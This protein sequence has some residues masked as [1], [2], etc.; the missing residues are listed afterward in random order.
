MPRSLRAKY[1]VLTEAQHQ[2]YMAKRRAAARTP[3]T[4][5]FRIPGYAR[6]LARSSSPSPSPPRTS[7]SFRTPGYARPLSRPP[8]PS[9]SFS[10]Q[11]DIS[12]PARIT[13]TPVR[14]R[15]PTT[16]YRP[17]AM[18]P[19]IQAPQTR[20][21]ADPTQHNCV[22]SCIVSPPEPSWH[23]PYKVDRCYN[24]CRHGIT[25][26]GT[27]PES[28]RGRARH[29]TDATFVSTRSRRLPSIGVPDYEFEAFKHDKPLTAAQMQAQFYRSRY[30]EP[31]RPQK[32]AER[33]H[34]IER[35]S[36][37]ILSS[38]GLGGY[39][40][41]GW[42]SQLYHSTKAAEGSESSRAY[43]ASRNQRSLRAVERLARHQ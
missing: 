43:L 10:S 36:S 18:N 23:G 39:Q 40:G 24:Y 5:S 13:R 9:P 12:P 35:I 1:G 19:Y 25:R 26:S 34:M 29:V 31:G 14:A 27:V 28:E 30:N 38:M 8:S 22:S 15:P 3:S 11:S 7:S 41:R 37:P 4:S 42:A 33:A 32:K 16:I 20:D 17:T 6:P 21:W 2:A